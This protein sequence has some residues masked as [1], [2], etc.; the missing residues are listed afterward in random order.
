MRLL[1]LPVV[2]APSEGAGR[3]RTWLVPGHV[4]AA[5]SKDYDTLLFGA[6]RLMRFLTISARSFSEPGKFRPLV[7]EL[8]QSR[9]PA[10]RMEHHAR[11]T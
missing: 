3:R 9:R 10:R 1:G 4:W 7:P 6:P 5:A 2:Q 8:P 11:G